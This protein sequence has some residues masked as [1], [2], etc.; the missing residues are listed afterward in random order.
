MPAWSYSSIKTFEQCP[1]KYFHLKVVK[2]V[3][4]NPGPEAVYGTEV[5]LA[6]EEFIRDGKPVP[7]KYGFILPVVERLAKFPG[8]KRVEMKLGLRKEG[9]EFSPCSFFD[10]EV[11]YRGI[12]D[13]LI[14]NGERAHLLDYKTGK[15]AKY[16]DM[17]Q[18]DLMAGAVFVHYP[19]VQE[20]KSGLLYVVSNEFPKKTHTREKLSEYLSV[21]DEQLERLDDAMENGVFNPKSGPLCGWCPVV[22]CAHWKPKRK[23]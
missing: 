15:N 8:E 3:K 22:E 5:H 20:I 23:R 9:N 16:A 17:K 12:I 18:L 4:D 11:W 7:D 13:L 19:E 6:A 21:F 10:K 2:D 1:K 14:V